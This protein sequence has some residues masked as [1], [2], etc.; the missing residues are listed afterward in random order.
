MEKQFS[1]DEL[2]KTIKS[3]T[4][5]KTPGPDGFGV[6]FYYAFHEQLAPILLRMINESA[7]THLLPPS[8][9]EANICLIL[10][11]N[12]DPK[13]PA[14]YRPI[15]LL[16]T[17]H[18][19]ITKTLATRLN[20]CIFKLISP[21]QCGFI[22]GR[23]S[24]WNVRRLLNILYS[25]YSNKSRA[26]VLTL[27]AQK[28]FDS[29]EYPYLFEVLSRFGFGPNF[30]NWVKII[31]AAPKS[32][33]TS[34]NISSAPFSLCRGVRQG[35]C[36]SPFLFNLALEP[37]AIG[38]RSHSSIQ[39]IHMGPSECLTSLYADDM[40][41]TLSNPEEGIPRLLQ[42]MSEFG[43]I[44]GFKI[45]WSKSELM[46]LGNDR[47]LPNC[48]LKIVQDHVTYLG[49]KI[50]KNMHCLFNLNFEECMASLKRNIECWRTLPLSMIGRV[51]AIKM[52]TLPKFL[53]LF[54]NLPIIIPNEF[55]KRLEKIILD[56]IWGFKKHRISKIHLYRMQRDGGLG[57]PVFQH[58][59]WAANI[60]AM[61][62]WQ[63]GSP[64]NESLYTAPLWLQLELWSLIKP[65]SSLVSILHTGNRYKTK[66]ISN[67]LVVQNSI[68]I[69]MQIKTH[70]K[71]PEISMFTPISHNPA[72][73]PGMQDKTYSAWY[74][75]G[76]KCIKNLYINGN[77]ASFE[78]LMHLY[79][80]STSNFFRYLQI[81]SFVRENMTHFETQGESSPQIEILNLPITCKQLIGKCVK[82]LA[83]EQVVPNNC[84]NAWEKEMGN[85]LPNDIWRTALTR[86]NTCSINSLHRLIQFKV[87]HRY[88][89][90]KVKLSKFY[91]SV[92]PICDKC[93][94]SEGTLLHMFWDC[95]L[96]QKFWSDIFSFFSNVYSKVIV[97]DREFAILGASL[98]SSDFPLYI[99]NAL[100]MGT[101]VAKRLILKDWKANS[102]PSVQTWL[103]ELIS[104]IHLEKLRLENWEM[105]WR[106][107][108]TYLDTS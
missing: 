75:K 32:S 97:L 3:F 61:L 16:N 90:S 7:V 40:L 36:L 42:Y 38:I 94:I 9:Y 87:I 108:L 67:S 83:M 10:K 44:S 89:Y 101:I 31:Y 73:A 39:G 88:H 23:F 26:A 81:R 95:P 103:N 17:D 74:T 91:E 27:D 100:L 1:I 70:L 66:L 22:P 102:T 30:I 96:I 15:S 60:R 45:N 5:G 107:V 28:A 18:K 106:P 55:F 8:L 35:D 41:I 84:K 86:I 80:L 12:K 50:S 65:Y 20:Q 68:K 37:L 105:S 53:Y 85:V 99:Q 48:P 71:I 72:F 62:Y 43:Q 21:D 19:I 47:T 78:D 98:M 14:N 33:V 104:V 4:L 64:L 52:I 25:D 57:L 63:A 46:F 34:N 93:N 77:F 58:Y 2:V 29:I 51:N 92:S 59:Y 82:L 56:F 79:N 76:I 69:L 54:Q 49:L 24:F 11:K 13:E 6:E